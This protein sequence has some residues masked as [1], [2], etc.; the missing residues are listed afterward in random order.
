MLDKLGFYSIH[1]SYT[2]YTF[3]IVCDS[4]N[5]CS[6]R[7]FSV[8]T[9]GMNIIPNAR[10]VCFYPNLK[11]KIPIHGNLIYFQNRTA[12]TYPR[13]YVPMLCCSPQHDCFSYG[14]F[15]QS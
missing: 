10:Y 14:N 9:M 15:S 3:L 6:L 4:Y 1:V 8:L 12:S 11:K 5:V 2:Q 13:F 7:P